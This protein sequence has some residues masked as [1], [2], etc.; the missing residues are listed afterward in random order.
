LMKFSHVLLI[1]LTSIY[2][3]GKYI[4]VIIS[5]SIHVLPETSAIKFRHFPLTPAK[6]R[7]IG[8]FPLLVLCYTDGG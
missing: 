1:F 7:E 4:L 5:I 3:R 6:H 8:G 2:R